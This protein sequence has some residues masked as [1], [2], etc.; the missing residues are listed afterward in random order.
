ME[1]MVKHISQ[2]YMDRM[3]SH[4][5]QHVSQIFMFCITIMEKMVK[6]TS[7]HNMERMSEHASQHGRNAIY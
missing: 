4:T 5:S 2:Q 3:C 6:H 1:G 7:Q